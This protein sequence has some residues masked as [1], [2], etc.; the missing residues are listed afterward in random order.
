MDWIYNNYMFAPI[1]FTNK[2]AAFGPKIKDISRYEKYAQ[3]SEPGITF[4]FI[5]HAK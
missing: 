5:T 3:H 1:A 2:I 4:E